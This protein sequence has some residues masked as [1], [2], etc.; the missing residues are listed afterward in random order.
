MWIILII[1]AIAAAA[2]FYFQGT[3]VPDTSALLQSAD[4]PDVSAQVFSLLGQIQSLHIDTGL[5]TDPG[6]L[7]LRDYS[8]AIPSLNVGRVNPFAP[9]PG[10]V[11][12]TD[13]SAV[14]AH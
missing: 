14:P 1:V 13:V 10:V 4:N 11:N 2:Y 6:Y 8:V 12:H 5:F 9:L 3:K 7:T